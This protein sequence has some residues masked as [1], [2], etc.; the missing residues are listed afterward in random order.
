VSVPAFDRAIIEGKPL[1]RFNWTMGKDGSIAV[2]VETKPRAMN[3]W[4]ATNPKARDF[5]RMTIGT[6]CQS[7][8]LTPDGKG[9]YVAGVPKP[10]AEWTAFFV[11]PVFDRGDAPGRT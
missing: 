2:E 6:A 10:A 1:P 8:P 9:A 7:S 5:R 11:E 4:Q 3:L